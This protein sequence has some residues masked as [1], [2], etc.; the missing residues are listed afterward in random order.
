MWA[1]VV[2]GNFSPINFLLDIYSQREMKPDEQRIIGQYLL[3]VV[4]SYQSVILY[5][6]QTHK[7]SVELSHNI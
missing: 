2:K 5:Q 4:F 6:P 3:I 7:I 1:F